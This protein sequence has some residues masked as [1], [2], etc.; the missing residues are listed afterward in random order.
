MLMA[1]FSRGIQIKCVILF[2]LRCEILL[3][4]SSLVVLPLITIFSTSL[5]AAAI[6]V[7][8]TSRDSGASGEGSATWGDEVTLKT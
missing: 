6:V 7:D 2:L 5:S 1:S 4:A 8:G 3:T